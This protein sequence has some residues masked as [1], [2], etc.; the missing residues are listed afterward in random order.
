MFFPTELWQDIIHIKNYL[1]LIENSHSYFISSNKTFFVPPSYWK[2]KYHLICQNALLCNIIFH[3]NIKLKGTFFILNKLAKYNWIFAPLN[4]SFDYDLYIEKVIKHFLFN[5]YKNYDKSIFYA[6]IYFLYIHS[7]Q[8]QP[9]LFLKP[10]INH[11]LRIINIEQNP[12]VKNHFL[13]LL[14]NII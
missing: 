6:L 2:G 4:S 14:D 5:F 10:H 9:S 7:S 12:F 13:H 1:I 8:I 3:T 11:V